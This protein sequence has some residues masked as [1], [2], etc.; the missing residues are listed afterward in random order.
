ASI[1]IALAKLRHSGQTKRGQ[2][3]LLTGFGAG[4]SIAAQVVLLP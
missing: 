4:L 2:L 3:A 1:P